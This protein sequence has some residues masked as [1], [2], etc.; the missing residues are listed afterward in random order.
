LPSGGSC[1][2]TSSPV[3]SAQPTQATT[4]CCLD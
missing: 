4:F 2:G 3:G 1:V